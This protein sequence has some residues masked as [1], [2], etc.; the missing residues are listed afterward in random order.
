MTAKLQ[1]H[2]LTFFAELL[3]RRSPPPLRWLKLLAR[4]VSPLVRE[5]AVYGLAPHVAVP[6]VRIVLSALAV[7]DQNPEVRDAA[8]EALAP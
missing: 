2:D 1:P 8:R 4:H 7:A 5:G 6:G 3:G